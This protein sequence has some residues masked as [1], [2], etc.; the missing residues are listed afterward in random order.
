MKKK[1]MHPFFKVLIVLFAIYSVLY[2]LNETGYYEKS[3]R[4]R[5]IITEQKRLEFE[6][7]IADGKVVDIIDYLPEKEDYGNKITRCANFLANKLGEVVE[8]NLEDLYKLLKAL[9]IG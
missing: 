6:K 3:V 7:D 8:Y 1:S 2:I 4:N 9:F 5:T